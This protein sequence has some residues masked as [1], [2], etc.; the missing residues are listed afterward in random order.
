MPAHFEHRRRNPYCPLSHVMAK[1]SHKFA[2]DKK[3]WTNA[4]LRTSVFAYMTLLQ[5]ARRGVKIA[6]KSVYAELA[7]KLGRTDKS[8]EYRMRNI[9]YV[10]ALLGRTWLPG[11]KPARNIGVEVAGK[12]EEILGKLE[13][14]SVTNRASFEVAVSNSR[15][16]KSSPVGNP[17]PVKTTTIITQHIRDPRIKAWVLFQAK[18]ICESCDLPAP[19][20]AID[21]P[22]LEVHHVRHLAEGGQDTISNAIAICPNCHRRLHYSL[23]AANL[24]EIIYSKIARLSRA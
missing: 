12:I 2:G 18:G 22:F 17:R 24:V 16:L 1:N 15:H 19:F 3:P 8:V 6:K 11:L 7:K 23:D 9:S 4:E 13:G 5:Q 14:K 20:D 10:L 21:G